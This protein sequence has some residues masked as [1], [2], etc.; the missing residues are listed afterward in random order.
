MDIR[1]VPLQIPPELPLGI[2]TG[3]SLG[4]VSGFFLVISFRMP[5]EILLDFFA[6]NSLEVSARIPQATSAGIPLVISP[7]IPHTFFRGF[8]LVFHLVSIQRFLQ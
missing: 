2:S 8:I 5:A 6:G 7:D 1:G 3:I 4:Y